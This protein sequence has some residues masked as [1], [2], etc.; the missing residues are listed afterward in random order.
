MTEFIHV[1]AMPGKDKPIE[2]EKRFCLALVSE[3]GVAANRLEGP[4][5]E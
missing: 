4:F 2:M 3:W 1:C 5:W